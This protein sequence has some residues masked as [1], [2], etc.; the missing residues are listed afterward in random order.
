[1]NWNLAEAKNR[2]SEVLTLAAKEG[3]Q[4]INRRDEAFVV[5][6]RSKYEELVGQRPTFRDWIL[7]GPR[8]DDLEIPPRDTS[9]MR[10]VKL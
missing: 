9:S 5:L 8:V 6:P 10:E 4:T 1:M 2:L 3:P 7:N